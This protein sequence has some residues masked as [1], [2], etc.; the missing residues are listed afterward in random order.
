[1]IGFIAVAAALALPKWWSV[2]I[3]RPADRATYETLERQESQLRRDILAKH[4]LPAPPIVWMGTADGVYFMMRPR[5]D[6]ADVEKPSTIPAEI[7]KE[8]AHPWAPPAP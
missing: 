4:G 7:R 5:N 8:I 1:M 2:H 6:F 3:D